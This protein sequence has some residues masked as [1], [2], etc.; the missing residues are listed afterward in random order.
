[1]GRRG[2]SGRP[3][4][5][6]RLARVRN[7]IRVPRKTIDR[8]SLGQ[9]EGFLQELYKFLFGIDWADPTPAV[10]QVDRFGQLD[11]VL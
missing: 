11:G 9:A 5:N 6:R 7:P 1:M 10:V 4:D 3:L 8:L 2:K